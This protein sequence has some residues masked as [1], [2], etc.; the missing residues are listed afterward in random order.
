VI[1]NEIRNNI[2]GGIM[3]EAGA[4]NVVDSASGGNTISGNGEYGLCATGDV[5]GS[6]VFGNAISANMGDGLI[7]AKAKRLSVGSGT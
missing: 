7:V 6:Q 2:Q 1:G 4:R 3:I 5:A